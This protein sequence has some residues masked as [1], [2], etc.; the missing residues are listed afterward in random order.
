MADPT[1]AATQKLLI[2]NP[3]PQQCYPSNLLLLCTNVASVDFG[4]QTVNTTSAVQTVILTNISSANLQVAG[5]PGGTPGIWE[6]YSSTSDCPQAPQV[7]PAGASCTY[8]ITFRPSTT[9]SRNGAFLDIETE[10]AVGDFGV[11]VVLLGVGKAGG[12]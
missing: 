3:S 12:S 2:F 1:R 11:S 6:D 4:T 7:L 5:H 9:G 10:D 8:S